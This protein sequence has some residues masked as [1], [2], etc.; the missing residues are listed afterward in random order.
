MVLRESPTQPVHV[1]AEELPRISVSKAARLAVV[2]LEKRGRLT[3]RD[4]VDAARD[5]SSPLHSEFEWDD[6]KAADDWRIE[7]AR[8]LIRSVKVM[9]D[10][11]TVTIALPRYVRDTA[12]ENDEQGYVTV[13]QIRRE[14]QNAAALLRYEFG[15]AATHCRRALA[16]AEAVG[17][18]DDAAK[19]LASI[20]RLLA[21]IQ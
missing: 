15:R 6:G 3:P 18:K 19:V 10:E 9:V 14:P 2:D 13:E 20:E 12:R 1:D 11:E 8:R 7:Q 5:P 21:R 4:L 17:I 16:I